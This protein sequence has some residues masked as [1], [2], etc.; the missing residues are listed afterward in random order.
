MYRGYKI[1][2]FIPAGRERTMSI[3][4]NH[5][6]RFKD[7]PVD[8]VLLCVNTKDKN[9]LAYINSLNDGYLK[10]IHRLEGGWDE[11]K[12][13]N[14]GKFYKY[15]LDE[16]TIY[17]RFDDDI[18]YVDDNFFKNMLDFRIDNRSYLCVMAN[19]WNNAIISYIAQQK[20]MIDKKHGE[21]REMFCMDQVGW[22]SGEF[23]VHLHNTLLD[24]IK[25]RK[26]PELFFDKQ[27]L[28]RVRRFS[29]SCFS[30]FGRDFKRL[31]NGN[32]VLPD[33]FANS[34]PYQPLDEEMFLTEFVT[35]EYGVRNTIC[36]S[37]LVSHYTFGFQRDAV[38]KA[39]IL[40]RYKKVSQDAL[41]ASYY[42]LLEK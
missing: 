20:G 3:L 32:V 2:P 35:H 22:R 18:V 1:V 25:K 8:E 34:G 4:V 19:I 7:N 5:L 12:Q 15:M 29:I 9:D 28:D 21:V 41:S 11:P 30:F 33:S 31:F 17:I 14:T 39:D 23:A 26:T 24:K 42:Q 6:L 37:A 10:V 16:D 27:D 13:L 36:G 40:D 38:N